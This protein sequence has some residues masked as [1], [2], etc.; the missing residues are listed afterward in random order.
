MPQIVLKHITK[1]LTLACAH[2]YVMQEGETLESVAAL[3]AV[4]P[5][6]IM[7]LNR[8]RMTH[9]SNPAT[10]RAGDVICVLPALADVRYA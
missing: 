1:E 2:Q 4:A 9:F 5:E 3:L 7:A 10:L 6:D 8:N